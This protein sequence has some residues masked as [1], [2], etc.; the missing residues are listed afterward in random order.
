MQDCV[1]DIPEDEADVIRVNGRGKMMVEGFHLLLA[2]LTTEAFHQE[3]LYICQIVG[4]SS[5]VREIVTDGH[6]LYFLLQQICLI[7]EKNDGCFRK[8]AVVDD[9][10][11]Y[12]ERLHQPVGLTVFHK[13]LVKF[14]R[15]RQEEHRSDTVKALEPSPPL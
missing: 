11:E 5:E 3:L 7:E 10:V 1:F 13:N 8:H 6:S 12:V 15:R 2:P 9:G 14:A 4:L